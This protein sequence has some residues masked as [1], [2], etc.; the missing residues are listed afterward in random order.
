MRGNL[1][2][3][4]RMGMLLLV[5]TLT[6]CSSGETASPDASAAAPAE[7]AAQVAEEGGFSGK[8]IETMNAGG[9]T[10][11]LV[12]T[13]SEQ[14]WAAG[15]ESEV[16]IG[17]ELNIP[18]GMPMEDFH[19]Q[20]LDRTFDVVYFVDSFQ[21]GI[22]AGSPHAPAGMPSAIPDHA[23]A[24]QTAA[25]SQ[26]SADLADIEKAAGGLTV[27]EIFAGKDNL[28]GK[29]VTVRGRVVKYNGGIM[30]RNWLHLRDG[31]GTEGA[32]DLTVTTDDSVQVGD[33]VLVKGIVATDQDFGFGYA[34]EI[35]VEKAKVTVE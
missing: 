7:A 33:L 34:Y 2:I 19:S 5:G 11:V 27:A 12:D 9:Y 18:K 13:G 30:D 21:G 14:I 26:P 17:E 32:N 29:E 22:G 8:I 23:R 25:P 28:A 31:S 4:A 3:A 15:P 6:A 24:E 10:Y 16:T 1:G 35:L 20:T